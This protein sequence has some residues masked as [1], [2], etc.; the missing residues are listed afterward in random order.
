MNARDWKGGNVVK[1][2]RAFA[3]MAFWPDRR[4]QSGALPDDEA[5]HLRSV[6]TPV[7]SG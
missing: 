1:G 3:E 6:L 4:N 5:P 7:S 2:K